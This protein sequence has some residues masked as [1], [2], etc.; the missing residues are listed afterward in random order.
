MVVF[1]VTCHPNTHFLVG[2]RPISTKALLLFFF[3]PAAAACLVSSSVD[4]T[5]PWTILLFSVVDAAL[6]L[7]NPK[8]PDVVVPTMYLCMSLHCASLTAL[9]ALHFRHGLTFTRAPLTFSSALS[10]NIMTCL[11]LVTLKSSV[12]EDSGSCSF[13]PSCTG[14]YLRSFLELRAI[15]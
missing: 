8:L 12:R 15:F 7:P 5:S 13:L 2:P 14:R 6:Q 11:T 1:F 4:R 10:H 9:S 3:I